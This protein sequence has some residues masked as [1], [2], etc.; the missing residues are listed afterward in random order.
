MLGA[1]DFGYFPVFKQK[2]TLP[3]GL[4]FCGGQSSRMGRDKSLIQ[5]HGIAQWQYAVNLL[6]PLCSR[7]VISCN[8]EQAK[9]FKTQHT[10]LVDEPKYANMGPMAGLLTAFRAYPSTPF[11]VLGCD[12]PLVAK[13]DL[14]QLIEGRQPEV[15]A[16]CLYNEA[17]QSEEPL[18]AI[19]EPSI[20]PMLVSH[21]KRGEFSLR[22]V[23]IK[24]A[25]HRIPPSTPQSLLTADTPEESKQLLETIRANRSNG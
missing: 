18:V 4:I 20:Y 14:K 6:A 1:T 21:Y 22:K 2:M 3:T 15:D 7:I 12:Y 16:V 9:Q 23:L 24:S 10:L 13:E 8:T 5:Y 25:T 17:G 19:Y 11:L